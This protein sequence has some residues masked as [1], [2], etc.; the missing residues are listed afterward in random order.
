[1]V[2]QRPRIAKGILR[3][4]NQTGSITLPDFRQYYKATEIKTVWYWYKNRHV[5]QQKRIESPEINSDTYTQFI[6]D[7]GGKNIKWLKKSLQQVLLGKLDAC[8]AVKLEHIL[9]P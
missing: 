8:K 2:P 3:E 7:D 1:M 9:M 4:K 6:F 5:D